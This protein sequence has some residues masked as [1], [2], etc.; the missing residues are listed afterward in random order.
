MGRKSYEIVPAPSRSDAPTAGHEAPASVLLTWLNVPLM[1]DASAETAATM[2]ITIR[3]TSTAYSTA[4]GP[5]SL[6]RNRRT[7]VQK[8]VI[9]RLL[10]DA[11]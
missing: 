10:V 2:P 11:D 3:P 6:V 9:A 7:L 1:L 5:S 8:V 4:V